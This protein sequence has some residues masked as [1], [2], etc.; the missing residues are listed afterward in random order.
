M[1]E[2]NDF[3]DKVISQINKTITDRVFLEI[4]SDRELMQEY[5]SLVE[6][7]GLSVVNQTIGKMVKHRYQLTGADGRETDPKSTLIRSHQTFE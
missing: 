1:T 6:R 2:V 7:S 4:Q 5:L 3:A